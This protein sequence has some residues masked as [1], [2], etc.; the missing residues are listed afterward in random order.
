[1]QSPK[2]FACTKNCMQ[3]QAGAVRATTNL[4]VGPLGQS[5]YF[6]N[7]PFGWSIILFFGFCSALVFLVPFSFVPDFVYCP[8]NP[9]NFFYD[10]KCSFPM[11]NIADD[12]LC[13]HQNALR[14][15]TCIFCIFVRILGILQ[16]LAENCHTVEPVQLNICVVRPTMA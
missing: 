6:K 15:Y 10:K 7:H 8:Y 12:F 16:P 2:Y 5:E 13:C 4:R 9:C 11:G 3:E 1:M 14:I